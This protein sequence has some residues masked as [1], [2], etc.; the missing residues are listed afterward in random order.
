MPSSSHEDRPERNGR[1][2][3]RAERNNESS[4][5]D[6]G[7]KADKGSDRRPSSGSANEPVPPPFTDAD[8]AKMDHSTAMHEW[9]QRKKY[10]A[11]HQSLDSA[12]KQRL[13]E[14]IPKLQDQ[15]K[16]TEAKDSA[17]ATT[18][19]PGAPAAPAPASAPST[20]GKS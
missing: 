14:E 8:I 13:T 15:M 20:G 5:T 16:K 2:R 18:P 4:S 17:P 1:R 6:K 3:D 19:A 10:V 9:S 12:S 7:E 11:T